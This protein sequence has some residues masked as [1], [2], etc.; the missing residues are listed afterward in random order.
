MH[1]NTGEGWGNWRAGAE[2]RAFFPGHGVDT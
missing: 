1:G 2:L